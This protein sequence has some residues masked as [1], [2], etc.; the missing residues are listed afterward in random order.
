MK[1]EYVKPVIE[2]EEF[3]ANEY[4]A[5][6][7]KIVCNG[8]EED[9]I[10]MEKAPTW[11]AYDSDNDGFGNSFS[12]RYY[13]GLIDGKEGHDWTFDGLVHLVSYVTNVEG[14]NDPHPNASV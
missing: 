2:S 3:V 10:K 8:G 13:K 11:D 6:C 7:Y 12:G 4:V 5:A 1:K 9:Y 14:T